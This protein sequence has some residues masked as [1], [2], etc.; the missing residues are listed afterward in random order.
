MG[1]RLRSAITILEPPG[2]QGSPDIVDVSVST[3]W[4]TF[5]EQGPGDYFLS[6]ICDDGESSEFLLNK[7]IAHRQW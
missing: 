4:Y 7:Q 6:I 5:S 3:G 2:I 1:P